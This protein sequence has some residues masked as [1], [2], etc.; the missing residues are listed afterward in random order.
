[1]IKPTKAYQYALAFLLL[2]SV[3][4]SC[5]K[6]EVEPV[7][8][9]RTPVVKT[10]TEI[11]NEWIY[12]VMKEIYYW[13]DEMPASPDKAQD[14]TEFFD[15]LLHSDDRFSHIVPNYQDLINSLNGVSKEAGYEFLLSRVSG[16]E[17]DVVAIVLYIKENSPAAAADLKRGDVIKKIN[18]TTITLSNYRDL[19]GEIELNH[20]IDFSRFNEA[21]AAYE[22]QAPLSLEVV[23]LAENPSFMDTVYHVGGKKVGYF[24]YNFFSP[25]TGQMYDKEVDQ[26]M[27]R[28][29]SEGINDLIL[30]LR[31]NSGGAVS[32]ATNL[33]S[34]VGKNIDDTKMFYENRWNKLYMDYFQSLADG[35]ARLRPKFLNKAE[36]VGE[37]LSSG[38]LYVLTGS[39]T[40]SASELIINGLRPYMDVYLI[41]EQTVGK[42]VGSV[43][44]E[45][46][47]NPENPY[48]ILP[49]VFRIYNSQGESDY[50]KGFVPDMEVD[51]FQLPMKALGDVEE[52]LLAQALAVITGSTARIAAPAESKYQVEPIMSSIDNKLR[53]NRLIMEMP[54]GV[55]KK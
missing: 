36:K 31:Y 51:D 47:D 35:E 19:L 14:P 52:P 40:A 4:V 49:I 38:R 8:V 24:V 28:F 26:V 16:S 17:T 11:T 54:E 22:A 39:R 32:S 2:G 34:L 45:D 42:N 1:M 20:T 23:E 53:T 55:Q 41:G 15:A 13:T 44:L 27:A 25:G 9:D 50:D 30:D 3:T 29:K 37:N 43:P 18:G 7:V 21:T 12:D 48:G 33:A 10:P 5:Q 6:D 46:T